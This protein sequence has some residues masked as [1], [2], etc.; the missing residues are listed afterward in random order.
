MSR[1]SSII[2]YVSIV[3]LLIVTTSCG[4]QRPSNVLPPEKMK[5]F[6]YDFHI[7]KAFGDDADY[8]ERYNRSIYV[9]DVY[10]KHGITKEQFDS[11][12]SWYARNL[13]DLVKI[14]DSV[15]SAIDTN[16]VMI[17]ELVALQYQVPLVTA[18][19]DSVNIWPWYEIY[20]LTGT[21]LNNRVTFDLPVDSNFRVGD[22]FELNVHFNYEYENQLD[23][24][25]AAIMQMALYFNNDSSLIDTRT[26]YKSDLYQM[27]LQADSLGELKNIKGFIYL[28][29]QVKEQRLLVDSISLYRYHMQQ[30]DS[31]SQDVDS[32]HISKPD[33]LQQV[34]KEVQQ[35]ELSLE[36]E[37]Q[38]QE[39]DSVKR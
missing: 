3:V 37:L 8:S 15:R 38:I 20:R 2:K 11:S 35:E 36:N 21:P 7:A 19:G 12:M 1:F 23:S 18:P 10:L 24:L 31:L 29:P 16:K 28:P 39:L 5:A 26:I 34:I 30:K 33:S 6:L 17:D 25:S 4:P 14:Y 13:S 27:S 22:R 9:D 32:I